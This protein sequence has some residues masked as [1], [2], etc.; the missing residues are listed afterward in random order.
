MTMN[1]RELA[2]LSDRDLLV[3][4]CRLAADERHVTA[5]LIASLAELDARRLYLAE[6]CSSLFTYCTQ[7]LHLSEH[8]AYLRIEAARATRKY[9]VLLER[10]D[11]GD[12][13]LT[14]VGLLAPHLTSAN[15]QH[16]VEAARHKSKREVEQLAATLRPQPPV[17]SAIRPLREPTRHAHR[18]EAPVPDAA[19][20]LPA[21]ASMPS[22][23]STVPSATATLIAATSAES[24]VTTSRAKPAVAEPLDADRYK[25]EFTITRDTFEKLRR[26]QDLMRHTCASGDLAVVFQRAVTMLLEHLERTK[27]AQVS[28]PRTAGRAIA[29]SRHIPAAVRRAVWARDGGQ[30][31][32]VGTRG[33]C[34]ER[35]FLEFH[36]VVPFADGG[37]A[38]AENIRLRCRAHNQYESDRWFGGG[39]V[40]VRECR[41]YEGW[42]RTRSGPS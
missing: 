20:L 39:P 2:D 12:I 35:G 41:E 15:H 37:A 31:A 16:V 33:R 36:H 8:A 42:T 9:P 22:G 21:A 4:V 28:R 30:C 34:P 1:T 17:A 7:V 38:T 18:H 27:L 32:F 5:C 13:T 25:L 26:V 23:S 10:L 40:L 14:A 19:M 29:G 6:G 3:T 24:P 11:A